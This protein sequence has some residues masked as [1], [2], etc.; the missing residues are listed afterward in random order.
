[1]KP[2]V[3]ETCAIDVGYSNV[4]YTSGRVAIGGHVEIRAGHFPAVAPVLRNAGFEARPGTTGADGVFVTLGGVR[5][6]AGRGYEFHSSGSDVRS[7]PDNYCESDQYMAL[8]RGAMH[9]IAQDVG[10]QQSLVIETLVLGLPLSTFRKYR[11]TLAARFEGDHI[12][13]ATGNGQMSCLVQ[14]QKV[15]VVVQPMGALYQLGTANPTSPVPGWTLVVDVGGGTLDWFV[16]KDLQPNWIRSGAHKRSMLDCCYAIADKN[17]PAW[18]E[19]PDI[20]ERIDTA[21]RTGADTF[22]VQSETFRM[23][24]YRDVVNAVLAESVNKM[25]ASVGM[26]DN[27]NL[28]LVTG[29][30]AN[31]FANY[32]C[33]KH[34]EFQGVLRVDPDGLYANVKGFHLMGEIEHSAA[35]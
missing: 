11:L 17:N 7:V 15:L 34:P 4:K 8:A 21:L 32:L 27:L 5:Y 23:V 9:Y 25:L 13:E 20:I 12:L 30:G 1:M 10:A 16:A 14:V 31:L 26:T 19:Q 18:K 24:E 2:T 6:F 3:I 22:E 29:G 28:V 35:R 33:E